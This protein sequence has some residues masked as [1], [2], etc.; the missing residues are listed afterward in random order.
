MIIIGYSGH[1][2]VA[3]GILKAAGQPITGYCD[4]EEKT[5]DPFGLKYYGSE[6]SDEALTA[7]KENGGFIAIGTNS[8]RNNIYEEL[9]KKGIRFF[10]AVHPSAVVDALA[11]IAEGGVMIAANV[12]INPLAKIGT[13]VICNT[14]CVIEH[15]C[16][17]GDFAHIGPGAV[18]CG[19]VKIGKRSFVGANAVIRQGITIGDN[20]TIGAGSVVV[21]DVPDN[22]TV[23]GVPAK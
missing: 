23:L 11:M 14:S 15:E 8:V 7:M 12:S 13:G 9:S 1:S 6:L 4:K 16:V 2:F 18:L 19:N 17:V 22:V 3:C 5:F 10:N 21:K 20:A